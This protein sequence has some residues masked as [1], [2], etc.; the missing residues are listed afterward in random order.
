MKLGGQTI[1]V[2]NNGAPTGYD[3]VGDPIYGAQT[4]ST[5]AGCSVQE[6]R[7]SRDINLTDI[8][9]A[10]YR[11]FAPTTVPLQSTSTVVTIDAPPVPLGSYLGEVS[12]QAAMLALTGAQGSWCIR[13]DESAVWSLTGSPA[14]SLSS[15]T[16]LS[17]T[18]YLVNGVPAV[19]K[20][21]RGT[22]HHIECYIEEQAG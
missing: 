16:E 7:T 11:L 3:G 18:I 6:H 20:G 14:S 13:T 8:T 21:H 5:W 2:I 10:R 1:T 15:W 12:S 17:A 9:L 4:A 22:P 19:W